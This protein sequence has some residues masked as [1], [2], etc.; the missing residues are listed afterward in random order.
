M[1]SGRSG[2]SGRIR[3]AESGVGRETFGSDERTGAGTSAGAG[4]AAGWSER[5][6]C[7]E[8]ATANFQVGSMSATYE[9][10]ASTAG[11]ILLLGRRDHGGARRQARGGL[12]RKRFCVVEER[13]G[14]PGTFWARTGSRP[15]GRRQG[16][17]SKGVIGAKIG[18]GG[19]DLI[20]TSQT[21]KKAI[22]IGGCG[23]SLSHKKQ[24]NK[25]NGRTQQ[26]S[27]QSGAS[28]S[29][30]S[31]KLRTCWRQHHAGRV[32]ERRRGIHGEMK[33]RVSG[34]RMGRVNRRRAGEWWRDEG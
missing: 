3:G 18:R 9:E 20:C 15:V 8:L 14:R 23:R 2:R 30:Q 11:Q 19:R 29:A 5:F 34:S 6:S 27:S 22:E 24:T 25:D 13:V 31:K 16:T 32:P 26:G 10:I 12:R 4:T 17:V 28:D 7:T 33:R 1:R 21:S